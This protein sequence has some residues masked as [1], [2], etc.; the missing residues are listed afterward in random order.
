MN[1][2][3]NDQLGRLR[4]IF[5][6]PRLV[7]AF[8]EWAG[9][10]PTFA[11]YTSRTPYAG[12]RTSK[13]DSKKFMSFESFYVEI[14][15]QASGPESEDQQR[16]SKLRSELKARGK[17]PAK[18]DLEKWFGA[19]GSKWADPKTGEPLRAVTLPEDSELITRHEAQHAAPDMLV[20]NYSMLEYMLMRPIERTIFDQTSAW[21]AANP[22][23]KF[24]VVLDEAH[25]YR[26]AAGA[27]VGLLMRRLRARLGIPVE[28]F[29]VICATA[30]FNEKEHAGD[31]GSQLTGVDADSFVAAGRM[32]AVAPARFHYPCRFAAIWRPSPEPARAAALFTQCLA[33]AH[34]A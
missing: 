34:G 27:E 32:R 22:D 31:F 19:K 11:R 29:Q 3:V 2:L 9:R 20:T 24:T 26:G 23:E 5:G 13:R 16:A 30:S 18:P 14:E 33:Q 4:A 8:T 17:W 12:V 7:A 25:L 6:D 10:P 21:L 1:A 28:R 15:R